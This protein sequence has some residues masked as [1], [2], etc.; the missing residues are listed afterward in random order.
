VCG[1]ELAPRVAPEA[2]LELSPRW[3]AASGCITFPGTES[4]NQVLVFFFVMDLFLFWFVL[5]LTLTRKIVIEIKF[6]LLAVR[7]FF[8]VLGQSQ[9]LESLDH[10]TEARQQ[11]QHAP[12]TKQ[13]PNARDEYSIF[14]KSPHRLRRSSGPDSGMFVPSFLCADFTDKQ[15][16]FWFVVNALIEK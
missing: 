4:G 1:H 9:V 6:S 16:V 8:S 12:P 10:E 2:E 13:S 15:W 14:W 3:L 5:I 11:L 7:Y